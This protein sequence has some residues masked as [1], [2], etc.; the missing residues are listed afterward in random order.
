MVKDKMVSVIIP[1]YLQANYLNESIKSVLNQTY[2]NFEIIVVDDGSPD[3]V[4]N[5]TINYPQVKL[6][7]QSNQG[8]AVARN[9][10]M[11]NSKGDYLIFL[12]ADDRLLPNALQI[13]VT[14]LQ[15]R[16]DCA[17]VTGLIQE[18]NSDGEF[19][20]IPAQRR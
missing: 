3:N 14:F 6:I 7:K 17:F 18:I 15:S 10:G 11:C 8:A 12:D 16:P 20:Q 2:D 19:L 4:E 5:I 13:G 9:N 1:C